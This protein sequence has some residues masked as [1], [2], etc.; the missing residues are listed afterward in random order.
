[1]GTPET[2]SITSEEREALGAINSRV[3]IGT[4]T[5]ESLMPALED[6]LQKAIPHDFTCLVKFTVGPEGAWFQPIHFGG[7]EFDF[8]PLRRFPFDQM[9]PAEMLATGRPVLI[10]G[11]GYERFPEATYI[12]SVG[13][14]SCMLCP[15]KVFGAPFG[16]LAIGSRRRNAFSER[17]LVLAEQVSH[18]L[19]LAIS[20][21][22]TY[23]DI[24]ALKERLERENVY[25]K[26]E[27]RASVDFKELAGASPSLQ[28]TLKAIEK[29]AGTDSPVLL[30]GE[31]GTGKDLV[32]QAIHK[33]SS[34]K[35]TL[36][37]KLNCAALPPSLIESDLFGHEKGA[38][39]GAAA[40]K[41]GRFEVAD[42][43]TIF[44]DEVDEIPL[45]L[46]VKLLHFLD[47]HELERVG[48]SRTLRLNVRVIAATNADLEGAVSRRE[49]RADLYKRLKVFPIR[50]PPLRERREDMPMLAWH[51]AKKYAA[52]HRKE[53]TRIGTA[54]MQAI[55]AY[56][57]PGNVRELDHMIE[58]A[59][60][61]A[62]GPV[63]TIEE[64]EREGATG[65]P[66]RLGMKRPILQHR[67]KKL[68]ITKPRRA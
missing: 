32:A 10:P 65:A 38:F 57:W 59:V 20:N 35:D 16:F 12:E 60:I 47:T 18:H 58:R 40:R 51:F 37:I 53:I 56:P 9:A 17:D 30:T 14:L 52:R 24:R 26:E 33:L 7:F 23:E 50:V 49:F 66:A 22:L 21:I 61:L 29:A 13:L 8:T 11:H 28:K 34:R 43:G 1:M 64:L 45:D 31:T 4:V 27:I 25:L 3:V 68:G 42:Q 44:L 62:D 19:S 46:Q 55:T 54:A 63:L 36:L 6:I 15:L 39:N 2:A 67:R 5:V 41:I 48:G